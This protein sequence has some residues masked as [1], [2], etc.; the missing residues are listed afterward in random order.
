MTVWVHRSLEIPAIIISGAAG[1]IIGNG[2]LFPGSLSRIESLKKNTLNSLVLIAGI[3]PVFIVAGFLE[4]YVTRITTMPLWMNL[5]V[6]FV[7]F[8]YIIIMYVLLPIY[9]K[10]ECDGKFK[11]G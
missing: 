8:S 11:K 2:I 10:G 1:M 9:I 3:V 4:G 5:M 7:N 6:I